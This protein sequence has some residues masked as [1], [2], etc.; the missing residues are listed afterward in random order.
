MHVRRHDQDM[1]ILRDRRDC[2]DLVVRIAGRDMEAEVER[3]EAGDTLL[4]FG[5]AK[6]DA[7][8]REVDLGL[9]VLVI[10]DLQREPRALRHEYSDSIGKHL[11]VVARG[12]SAHDAGR[13]EAGTTEGR[14]A[15]LTIVRRRFQL[16]ARV[17]A[18]RSR[19]A[20][21]VLDEM[22]HHRPVAGPDLDGAQ[23][24]VLGEVRLHDEM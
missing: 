6:V 5:P 21:Y 23:E 1:L 17:F 11:R 12:P 20:V 13:D 10:V 4:Y 14:I 9:A 8:P 22:V 2:S 7:E 19:V 18:V 24:G 3:E 16:F 15:G